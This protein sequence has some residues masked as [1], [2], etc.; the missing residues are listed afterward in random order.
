MCQG[1]HHARADS[2]AFIFWQTG[3]LLQLLLILRLLNFRSHTE[4]NADTY[5]QVIKHVSCMEEWEC[6]FEI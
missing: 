6:R 5:G 2:T 4:G 1:A 3:E